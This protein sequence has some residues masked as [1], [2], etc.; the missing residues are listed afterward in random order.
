VKKSLIA[1]FLIAVVLV[2]LSIAVFSADLERVYSPIAA[3]ITVGNKAEKNVSLMICVEKDTDASVLDGMINALAAKS[4]SATFFV[5]GSWVMK[6]PLKVKNMLVLGF[7]LGNL[8]FGGTS[9]KSMS[10]AKQK[11]EI[12]DTHTIVKGMTG[13][14]MKVFTPPAGEYNKDTVKTATALGYTTVCKSKET[15]TPQNGD[16]VLVCPADTNTADFETLLNNY[17]QQNFAV[18][19]VSDNISLI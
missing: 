2:V 7:E 19:K 17:L 16:L 3:P 10:A 9:F 12:L 6:N 11:Q 5:S 18:I 1:N 4:S 15:G 8:G 13:V 14:D